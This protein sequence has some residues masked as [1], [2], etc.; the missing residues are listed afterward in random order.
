MSGTYMYS[1]REVGMDLSTSG[2]VSGPKGTVDKSRV[3]FYGAM[4]PLGLA[5]G[6]ALWR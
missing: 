3:D 5:Y 1:R 2:P 4:G 6:A